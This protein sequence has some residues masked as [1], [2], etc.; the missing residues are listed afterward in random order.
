M[1]LVVE[2]HKPKRALGQS[3]SRL[4]IGAS[5]YSV[6]WEV[7]NGLIAVHSFQ[8]IERVPL[9]VCVLKYEMLSCW[10]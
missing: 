6:C 3:V 7:E 8:Q 1:K 2:C 5:L 9:A 4:Q 10:L